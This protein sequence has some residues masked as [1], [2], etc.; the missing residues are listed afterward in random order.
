MGTKATSSEV[1]LES[2]EDNFTKGK[3]D[4]FK[5]HNVDVG[6]LLKIRIGHNQKGDKP[7]WHCESVKIVNVTRKS[8]TYIFPC[9]ALPK[10]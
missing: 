10:N 7:K 3:T 9:G 6:E 1:L 8:K 4:V 2:A 5:V